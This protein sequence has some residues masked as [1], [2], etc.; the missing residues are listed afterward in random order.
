M[1]PV[2]AA[3]AEI[4]VN[5]ENGEVHPLGL[6]SFVEVG[7][8]I[9]VWHRDN[10]PRLLYWCLAREWQSTAIEAR[11]ECGARITV[12]TTSTASLTLPP[13]RRSLGRGETRPY[14][15]R[16]SLPRRPNSLVLNRR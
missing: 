10:F 11:A 3:R 13:F 14:H 1:E 7:M 6:R 15:G 5:A 4:G 8:G 16:R 12:G 2:S 9:V